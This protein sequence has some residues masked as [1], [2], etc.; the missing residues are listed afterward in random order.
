[1]PQVEDVAGPSPVRLVEDGGDPLLQLGRAKEETRGIEIALQRHRRP[2]APARL[3][4]RNA[5]VDS[6]HAGAGGGELRK[7][8]S[9]LDAEHDHWLVARPLQRARPRSRLPW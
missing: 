5:P 6:H 9:R 1:M 4:E 2:D 3:V 8:L 7:Q